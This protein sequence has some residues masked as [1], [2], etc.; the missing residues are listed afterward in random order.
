VPWPA[1][2]AAGCSAAYIVSP[3]QLIPTFI[4]VIG[5]MDDLAVLF[6]GMKAIRKWTPPAVLAECEAKARSSTTVVG[7]F[8]SLGEIA[9]AARA[10]YNVFLIEFYLRFVL[11]FRFLF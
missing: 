3:I 4:P 2:A 11:R 6:W 8:E 10:L 5:Q 7:P 1:K 9:P